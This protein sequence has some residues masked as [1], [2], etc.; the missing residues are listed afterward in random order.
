MSINIICDHALPDTQLQ[1]EKVVETSHCVYETVAFSG[2]PCDKVRLGL[3]E[4]LAL[5]ERIIREVSISFS[6]SFFVVGK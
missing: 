2:L 4:R 1:V 5:L 6:H 3:L